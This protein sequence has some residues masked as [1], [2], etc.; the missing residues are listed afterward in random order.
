MK[1]FDT[2]D[3]LSVDQIKK[4]QDE[5]LAETIIHA[6]ERSSYYKKIFDH[7]GLRP[8]D[9]KGSE[10]IKKLPFTSREEIQKDNWA[11]LAVSKVDI[12]EIVSTT[13]TTGEPAFIAL[14]ENDLERLAYNEE[15]SFG[16]TGAGKGDL[17]HIAVTCDNLFIAGIAYYSGLIRL[18]ASVVRIGPQNIIRHFDLI[19]KLKSNGIV[20]VPSFM[21]QMMRRAKEIGLDVNELGIEKIVLIRS[22]ERR[23]GK[24]C[25]SRWSP[26]H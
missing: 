5:L 18:G 4:I 7:H 24:E 15:K 14:T 6:Y 19:Q 26:Y 23:V 25:R 11:F 17:F 21:I 10:D 16:L 20:A 3:R 12:A 9:I 1:V 8:S 13:G 2:I 22:E